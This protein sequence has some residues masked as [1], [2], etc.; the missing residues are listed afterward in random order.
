M[1]QKKNNNKKHTKT[2]YF[3]MATI[4]YIVFDFHVK[5]INK[6]VDLGRE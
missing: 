6:E 1:E 3:L 4:N 5:N 2:W